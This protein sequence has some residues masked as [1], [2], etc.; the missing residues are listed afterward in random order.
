MPISYIKWD[1]NR[2]MCDKFSNNLDAAH[3]GEFAH[4]FIL[5]LYHVLETLTNRFPDV[6]FE[7]CSG[8]GGRYDCGMLYYTPQI[9]K[10][11]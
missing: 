1:M 9:K 11:Q 5:G 3:Q 2:S 7:G 10:R 4:R 6:L 8:G